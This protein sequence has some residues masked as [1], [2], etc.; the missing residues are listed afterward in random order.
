MAS[1]YTEPIFP[2]WKIN[3]HGHKR[4]NEQMMHKHKNGMATES[5]RQKIAKEH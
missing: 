3:L 1:P 2:I 4:M 5:G